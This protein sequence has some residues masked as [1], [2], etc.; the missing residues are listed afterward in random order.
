M[1]TRTTVQR[2][3]NDSHQIVERS[4]QRL[5]NDLR[6]IGATIR[7][8]LSKEE[9]VSKRKSLG[10]EVVKNLATEKKLIVSGHDASRGL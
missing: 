3:F 5:P 10:Q 8:A 2:S 6:T 7:K 4:T 9:V 1:D